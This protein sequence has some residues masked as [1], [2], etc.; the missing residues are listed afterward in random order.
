MYVEILGRKGDLPKARENM[1]KA[2][3]SMKKC[4]TDG[5]VQKYEGEFARL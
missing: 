3:E 4:G 2:I 5:W 1:G